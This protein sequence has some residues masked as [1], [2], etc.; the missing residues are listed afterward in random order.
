MSSRS[1][2]AA[3]RPRVPVYRSDNA[4]IFLPCAAVAV[5]GFAVMGVLIAV[6]GFPAFTVFTAAAITWILYL[7]GWRPAYE[8]RVVGESV[9]WRAPFASGQVPK[10]RLLRSRPVPLRFDMIALEDRE[11][12]QV[13]VVWKGTGLDEFLAERVFEPAK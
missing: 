1:D 10:G 5:C 8:L 7:Y 2:G 12:R 6:S 9:V 11:G 13:V 4:L 3:R